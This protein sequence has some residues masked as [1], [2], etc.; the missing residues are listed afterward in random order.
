MQNLYKNTILNYDDSLF[1]VVEK[2]FNR[3]SSNAV[4]KAGAK[5]SRRQEKTIYENNYDGEVVFFN[6]KET[7]IVVGKLKEKW[8]INK[9][10]Q[11]QVLL[12]KNEEVATA[13]GF[14]NFYKI[15]KESKEYK[16]TGY[17]NLTTETLPGQ[18]KIED[19]GAIQRMVY[20]VIELYSV[21]SKERLYLSEFRIEYDNLTQ[22]MYNEFKKL[23]NEI[24]LS[25]SDSLE[26]FILRLEKV[27][28]T[29]NLYYQNILKKVFNLTNSKDTI[30]KE[31]V[32]ELKKQ[33]NE[34]MIRFETDE[35]IEDEIQEVS[36]SIKVLN[37]SIQEIVSWYNYIN[38]K[39]KGY[40]RYNTI[41]SSKWQQYDN[42]F[43]VLQDKFNNERNYFR[44]AL[45]Y[46]K[47]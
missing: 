32:A 40:V 10:N 38:N 17:L 39:Q 2:I 45:I 37:T 12:M 13:C 36:V 22:D 1:K 42:V 6:N 7:S 31:M 26:G 15:F 28:G 3:R 11:L 43:L 30:F 14:E 41:H 9:D 44:H 34:H 4:I 35:E 18:A 25:D 33:I 29:E 23:A 21:L 47:S 5:I 24:E 20:N 19:L 46:R 8:I 16:G 27:S